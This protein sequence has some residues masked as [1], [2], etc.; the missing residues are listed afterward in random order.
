MQIK[1][2][3]AALGASVSALV[4]SGSVHA[5]SVLDA[6]TKTALGAGF[7]DMKDTVLDLLAVAWPYIIGGSVIL[8][9][10]S[11]VKSLL[12]DSTKK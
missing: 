6:A 7:T 9:T 3:F 4:L 11:I 8:A 5:A 1:Q 2:K 12:R 10:P